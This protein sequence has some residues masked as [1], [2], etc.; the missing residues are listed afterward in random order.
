MKVWR[1]L[2]IAA[3]IAVTSATCTKHPVAIGEYAIII[4][5]TLSRASELSFDSGD[6]IGVTVVRGSEPSAYMSNAEFTSNGSVFSNSSAMWY[7][8]THSSSIRAYY[9]YSAAGEPTLFT[10]QSDQSGEGYTGSDFMTAT[11]SGVVPTSGSVSMIFHHRMVRINIIIDNRS[12]GGVT[13]AGILSCG[14]T[15][16]VDVAGE[17]ASAYAST[18][19]SDITAHESSAGR[20]Y[21]AIIAPQRAALT[22]YVTLDDGSQPRTATMGEADFV[23]GMQ[24]TARLTL[25]DIT[26]EVQ[27]SGEI[28]G[29]GD[30]TDLNP[31]DGST[32]SS[33]SSGQTDNSKAKGRVSWGGVE[34]PT[35]TLADGRTWMTV[36]LRY[37]PAGK[38][39][40]GDPSDGSGVWY[41]CNSAKAALTDSASAGRY[42]YLYDAATAHGGSVSE[43]TSAVRGI[44][45]EG[46]HLPTRAEFGA[47]KD[48]YPT[49]GELQ[50]SQFGFAI[51]GAI[52]GS[53]EYIYNETA[54]F[55]TSESD[56]SDKTW[57]CKIDEELDLYQY[58]NMTSSCGA[59]VR[60]IRDE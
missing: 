27:M 33:G 11:K 3:L 53:N 19:T 37:V 34:Y 56:S 39:V 13:E 44:C 31:A 36:N 26:M 16:T 6:R 22:F 4:D 48:A 55:W 51:S 14:V 54:S 47:L 8:G 24:Y 45:P 23:S 28:E 1:N 60:C 35:A 21:N 29:W 12:T 46:W 43:G 41:P 7:V 57:C 42:G 59:S 18:A 5:P 30:N 52:N 2:A 20:Q 25:T 32:D 58:F 38:S 49:V 40:S 17:S 15:A 10:V 9:P 50:A